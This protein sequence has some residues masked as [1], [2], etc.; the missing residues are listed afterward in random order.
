MSTLRNLCCVLAFYGMM[1]QG[2]L[3][4]DSGIGVGIIAGEPTGLSLKGWL[5]ERTAWAGA[6]A[7]S[8]DSNTS[9]H[10]HGDYL[11]H[12]YD[13]LHVENG[14]LPVYYGLGARVKFDDRGYGHARTRTG[15]RIPV[16]VNYHFEQAPVDLFLEVA[17]IL[18]VAP[19]TDFSI[20][21]A[22]GARVF[23]R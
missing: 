12:R 4:Q 19:K 6:A 11:I 5:T 23:F 8:F 22:I 14:R 3:A 10:L 2:A 1:T 13:L 9:F 7:W 21:A 20:N 15:I 17:P 18:D 16:G